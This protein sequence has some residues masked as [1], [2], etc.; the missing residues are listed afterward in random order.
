MQGDTGGEQALLI[1]IFPRKFKVSSI[2]LESPRRLG[3]LRRLQ[4]NGDH[5][6]HDERRSV[7]RSACDSKLADPRTVTGAG[8]ELKV[9]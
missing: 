7:S 6:P 1:R 3:R 4:R 8:R 2:P 5:E 9:T